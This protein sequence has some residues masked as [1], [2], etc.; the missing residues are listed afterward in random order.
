VTR[1]M[2]KKRYADVFK[3]DANW[4]KIKAPEGET[5]GWDD[6]ARPMCRTRPI[7]TA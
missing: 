1:E 4:Q 5:Y 6:G 7:S 2:F 3:G